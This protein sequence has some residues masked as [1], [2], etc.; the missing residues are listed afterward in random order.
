MPRISDVGRSAHLRLPD[1]SWSRA[2]FSRTELNTIYQ[3]IEQHQPVE[4]RDELGWALDLSCFL[5]DGSA[6]GW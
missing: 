6:A 1:S 5:V 4:E 3:L 2:G